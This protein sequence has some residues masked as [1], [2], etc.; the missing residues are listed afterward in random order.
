MKPIALAFSDHLRS[1]SRVFPFILLPLALLYARPA[2]GTV[3][4]WDGSS[5]GF[6]A[7]AANWQGNV[8]PVNGD[9]VHFPDG[10]SRRT[11]TNNISNLRLTTILFSDPGS[12]NYIIRGSAITLIQ[13]AIGGG[14]QASQTTGNNSVNCDLIFAT[15]QIQEPFILVL[16]STASL[17]IGGQ[18][19]LSGGQL[20]IRSE[21]LIDITGNITGVGDILDTGG[22]ATTLDGSSAN[23][24]VGT[25]FVDPTQLTLS[26]TGVAIPGDLQIHAA[27]GGALVQLQAAE[28][29]ADTADVSISRFNN[30][31]GFAQLDLQGFTETI[32]SLTLSGSEVLSSA[33]GSL[34]LNGDLVGASN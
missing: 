22:G 4:I 20:R 19:T 27:G 34:V 30:I 29:I 8:A 31:S 2:K 18:I 12:T 16:N 24:Y 26:Q 7:T 17:T 13:G 10:V 6:W 5:S 3:R 15:N 14:V 23:T 33:G 1:F 9:E 32:H 25:T 21:G 11:M 28:Q